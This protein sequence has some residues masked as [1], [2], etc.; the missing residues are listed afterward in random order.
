MIGI[1]IINIDLHLTQTGSWFVQCPDGIA[2]MNWLELIHSQ[3]YGGEKVS[4]ANELVS[5]AAL[6]SKNKNDKLALE[7]NE[8]RRQV[9]YAFALR[10]R[11]LASPAPL[12][13]Y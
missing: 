5:V 10:P 11:A 6:S 2:R 3:F 13:A 7:W 1:I 9:S 4:G 8:G 12:T